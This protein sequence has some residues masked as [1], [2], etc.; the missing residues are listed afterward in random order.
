MA[1]V[2]MARVEE[3]IKK[4]SA[5]EDLIAALEDLQ[6]EF[7]FLSEEMLEKLSA[8]LN[9]PL[10]TIS[11][12]ATFYSSFRLKPKG[13]HHVQVCRGTACHIFRSDK[14][15][16]YFEKKLGIKAGETTSDGKFSLVP[17]NCI[18]AC[19]KAPA[20]MI[21]DKVYGNLT[22]EKIDKILETLK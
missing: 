2:S 5:K 15:L 20:M 9:V 21:N 13:R 10:V 16:T 19:A 11:G 14:L 8:Q 4:Y 12:A 1:E 18:G 3:I 7:G 22:E 17:V 6:E